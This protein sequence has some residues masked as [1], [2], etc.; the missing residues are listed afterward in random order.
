[1]QESRDSMADNQGNGGPCAPEDR[2]IVTIFVR[3][4]VDDGA[5]ASE[6]SPRLQLSLTHVMFTASDR[7]RN[8]SEDANESDLLVQRKLAAMNPALTNSP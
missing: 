7:P 5:G 8:G 4:I 2:N 6:Y 1:M 3:R